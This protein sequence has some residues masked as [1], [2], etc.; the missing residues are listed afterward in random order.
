MHSLIDVVCLN[1]EMGDFQYFELHEKY[2]IL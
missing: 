1:A 2:L